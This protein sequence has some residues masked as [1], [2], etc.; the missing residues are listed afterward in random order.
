MKKKDIYIKILEFGI[1]RTEGFTYNEIINAKELEIKKWEKIIID[2]YLNNAY[3]NHWR[4]SGDIRAAT[5][6]TIFIVIGCDKKEHKEGRKDENTKYILNYD[7]RF[8]Y[9]DYVELKEARKSAKQANK[10]AIAAIMIA[11]LTI[12]FQIIL[13]FDR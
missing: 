11:V 7:S 12:L 13:T 4:S 10:N 9:I 3:M 5:L 1:N 2:K 8:K 6:E